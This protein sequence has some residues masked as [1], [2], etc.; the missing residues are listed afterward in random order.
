MVDKKEEVEIDMEATDDEESSE[1]VE[2]VTGETFEGQNYLKNPEV[3]GSI[4][5]TIK[6]I[7]KNG[8]TSGTNKEGI[9]FNIGIM[10]KNKVIKRYDIHTDKGVYTINTWQVYFKLFDSKK[11]SEGVLIGYSRKHNK[12]FAGAKL[13]ITRNMD[14]SHA[15]RKIAELMKLFDYTE[16]KAIEYQAKIKKAKTDGTLYTVVL[17]NE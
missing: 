4:E 5:F 11:E 16:E 8:K 2:E 1:K 6:K 7:V 9:P 13:K 12:S 3:G 10:D 15:T 14:G 17:L